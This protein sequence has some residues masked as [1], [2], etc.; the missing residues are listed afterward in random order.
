MSLMLYDTKLEII[1]SG[2]SVLLKTTE[3]L[4]TYLVLPVTAVSYSPL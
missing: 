1:V 3:I 4:R 2:K